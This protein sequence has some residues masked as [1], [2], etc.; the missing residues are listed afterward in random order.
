MNGQA[1]SLTQNIFSPC[2]SCYDLLEGAREL[3]AIS[4]MITSDFGPK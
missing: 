3:K 2:I 1:L 4:F